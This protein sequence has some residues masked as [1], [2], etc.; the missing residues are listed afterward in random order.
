MVELN[1]RNTLNSQ[2]IP[3]KTARRK[4][5]CG[6]ALSRPST[7]LSRGTFNGSN[8]GLSSKPKKDPIIERVLRNLEEHPET[9]P[10][11]SVISLLA[12]R[13]VGLPALRTIAEAMESFLRGKH[14]ARAVEILRRATV[15]DRQCAVV[16]SDLLRR[17]P[18]LLSAGTDDL[19]LFGRIYPRIEDPE[20]IDR[21]GPAQVEDLAAAFRVTLKMFSGSLETGRPGVERVFFSVLN[22][23]LRQEGNPDEKAA[24]ISA[25]SENLISILNA[26]DT[27]PAPDGRLAL[28]PCFIL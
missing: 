13:G 28:D 17:R 20:I 10:A 2:G 3:V 11:A 15:R 24:L 7:V 19:I 22:D 16:L 21:L 26:T 23:K 27:S 5:R 12:G 1:N 25:W 14:A 6:P 8:G 18:Q 9:G 4:R